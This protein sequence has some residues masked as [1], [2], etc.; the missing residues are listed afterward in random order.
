MEQAKRFGVGAVILGLSG[1]LFGSMAILDSA[2]STG[3][4]GFAG[5]AVGVV[6]LVIGV[7][8]YREWESFST[9]Q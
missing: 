1:L 9:N 2:E 4:F 7:G 5:I 8:K 3:V 6:L